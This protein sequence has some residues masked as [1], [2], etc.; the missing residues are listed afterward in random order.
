VTEGSI[1]L[2]KATT[3]DCQW[4]KYLLQG[5][6]E[7]KETQVMV[8]F[9][10]TVQCLGFT[11]TPK[12]GRAQPLLAASLHSLQHQMTIWEFSWY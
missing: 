6:A 3:L 1:L 11:S 2:G 12:P 9:P 7:H 5:S 10:T 8:S 4:G